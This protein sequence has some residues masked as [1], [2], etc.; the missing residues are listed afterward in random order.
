MMLNRTKI[1]KEMF[2]F[3]IEKNQILF[4]QGDIANNFY[5][6]KEGS[7][8]LHKNEKFI[9]TLIRRESIGLDLLHSSQRTETVKANENC[10][11]WVLNGCIFVEVL[12]Y[13]NNRNYE[14]FKEYLFNVPFFSK[15]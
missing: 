12:E 1:I 3:K 6:I 5:V 14:E 2:I 7:L 4:T 13:I 15:I 11:L 9:K 10:Q 8:I